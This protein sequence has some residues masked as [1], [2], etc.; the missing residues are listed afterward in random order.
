MDG[1]QLH[2]M[3]KGGLSEDVVLEKGP[4]GMEGASLATIQE[5]SIT[6]RRIKCKD[7]EAG[8]SLIFGENTKM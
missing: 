7:Y 1:A 8:S 4:K 5:K 2:R 3:D 6:G